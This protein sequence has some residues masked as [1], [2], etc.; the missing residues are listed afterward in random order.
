MSGPL[1]IIKKVRFT[2]TRTD[3]EG[4]PLRVLFDAH[5][6]D[7]LRTR[8]KSL[9]F[10]IEYIDNAIYCAE[11]GPYFILSYRKPS[12]EFWTAHLEAM[13]SEQ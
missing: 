13:H 9:G 7:E 2:V 10:A 11:H 8:L 3:G 5:S 6:R 1:I 4:N 12:G